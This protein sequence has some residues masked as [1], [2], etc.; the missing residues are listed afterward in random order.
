M[1]KINY[2]ERSWAIDLISEI[3]S[4]CKNKEVNI[5]RAGGEQTLLTEQNL[6]P[7]VLLYGD[8]KAGVIIQGW[9]L[10]MPDTPI[11]DEDFIDNA[12]KKATILGLDSFLLWN[13]SE[14]VLYKIDD[15]SYEIIKK[16]DDLINIKSREEVQKYED[17]WK[18]MLNKI[19]ND[20][21]YFFDKGYIKPISTLDTLT[22]DNL[23]NLILNNEKIVAENIKQVIIENVFL[24]D[25]I[26][27]WWSSAKFEYDEKM[28]IYSALSRLILVNWMNKF[29]F[30]NLLKKYH[31][32][33][34]LIENVVNDLNI[35]DGIKIINEISNSCD[36]KNIFKILEIHQYIPDITWNVLKNYNKLLISLR[37]DN[38]N[39]DIISKL[40]LDVTEKSS[41]KA[42]GQFV[43]PYNLAYF[44]S[45][46][47][48]LNK[49]GN[50]LDPCCGTGTLIKACHD[51]KKSYGISNDLILD[52][53][54]ASDKYQF[55]LQIAMISLS[56]PESFGKV[57]NIF[58]SDV[59]DLETLKKLSFIHPLNGGKINKK[60]PKFD[61]IIS[62]LP[63]IKQENIK[64][65]YG[66]MRNDINSS[67]KEYD[68]DLNLSG[69]SDFYAY[70]PFK[71]LDLIKEDGRI[72]LIVSNS[73]L[74]SNWGKDF[75]N[76]LKIVYNIKYVITSSVE[77]WFDNADVI[78]TILILE[79]KDSTQ[80]IL[81][82]KVSYITLNI[83]INNSIFIN[84]VQE[85]CSLIRQEKESEHYQIVSYTEQEEKELLQLGVSKNSLF[86]DIIWLNKIKNNLIKAN[87]LF[88]ISRGERRGWDKMFYPPK[89]HNIEKEYIQ[90]V[91][92][93]QRE[94]KGYI[95]KANNDAFC[96]N[97]TKEE[98][99]NLNH[100]N[101]LNWI[102]KFENSVNKKNKPLPE[103]LKRKNMFWYEMK[104]DTLA[105]ICISINPGDRLF[106]SRLTEKSFVNQRLIRFNIINTKF[107]PK[108]LC[109]LL[110]SVI[111]LFYVESLGFG[112]G[113]GALDL[114]ATSV[115]ENL[116]ML[117]PN[118]LTEKNK[119]IILEKY[120]ILEKRNVEKLEIELE[121]DDRIDFDKTLLK[122]FGISTYYDE[123]KHSLLKL[124]KRRINI[125]DKNEL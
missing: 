92:K 11:D 90:K 22:N 122:I 2:N 89:D 78:T 31:V 37:L 14:A 41:K 73:W 44:L 55:P 32:K 112:R 103:V 94:I 71:L 33:A 116:F 50:V 125:S 8:E 47:T 16:W 26:N 39:S 46:L 40:L 59:N 82:S 79:K 12:Y 100:E 57:L 20:L 69:K 27:V 6:F 19:L 117:N 52:S 62:N 63:F 106:F 24:E 105:D 109:A 3:N 119:K 87:E 36:F 99:I 56:N 53:L 96:C 48:V 121:L 93:S 91:V 51:M 107:D 110:N 70:I 68:S 15:E 95:T 58:Q 17:Q 72:G 85:L 74:S 118:L 43:T 35:E 1:V 75:Y 104:S 34:K 123:I 101:A 81:D 80:K 29:L 77:K 61:Y 97:V 115:K 13:C 5:R 65:Y 23:V 67:L 30:A 49:K 98:L 120:S 108:I 38:L 66:E 25:K 18:A 114:N 4:W 54:W 83:S 28:N 60:L 88:D 10:K 42:S 76:A 113:L 64:K 45:S 21:N 111:G 7:D 102:E 84:T 86:E 9:E 124:Y